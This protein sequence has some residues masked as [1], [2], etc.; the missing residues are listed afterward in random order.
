M[1]LLY[2]RWKHYIYHALCSNKEYSICVHKTIEELYGLKVY[3]S[4]NLDVHEVVNLIKRIGVHSPVLF[5]YINHH[6]GSDIPAR[7]LFNNMLLHSPIG[8]KFLLFLMVKDGE[9]HVELYT[10]GKKHKMPSGY[11]FGI[12]QLKYEFNN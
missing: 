4:K 6:N 11:M 8:T 5:Y 9:G 7:V 2:L 12:Y 3:T 1:K 10:R